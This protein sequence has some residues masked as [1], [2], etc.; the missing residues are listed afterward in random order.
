MLGHCENS[1]GKHKGKIEKIT[2]VWKFFLWNISLKFI[3]DAEMNTEGQN[4]NFEASQI[5]INITLYQYNGK[6]VY[7]NVLWKGCYI[8]ERNVYYLWNLYT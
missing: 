1:R 6:S 4:F 2:L 3:L 5:W 7:W 8:C